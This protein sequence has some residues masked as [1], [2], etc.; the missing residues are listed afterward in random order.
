MS[1]TI[2]SMA[3]RILEMKL[4]AGKF[5]GTSWIELIKCRG[6]S[7]AKKT[8]AMLTPSKC[9]VIFWL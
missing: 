2:E 4:R 7:T 8:E 1:K 9:C 3:G 6:Q 5:T